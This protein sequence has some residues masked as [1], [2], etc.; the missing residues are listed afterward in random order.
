MRFYCLD[1][2]ILD[3]SCLF[4]FAWPRVSSGSDGLYLSPLSDMSPAK[5]DCPEPYFFCFFFLFFSNYRVCDDFSGSF[6]FFL[7]FHNM[8]P[9]GVVSL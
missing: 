7:I 4:Y 9:F 6:Y 3:S 5:S 8:Y 1:L 2:V